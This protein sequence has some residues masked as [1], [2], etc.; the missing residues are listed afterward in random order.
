MDA[1]SLLSGAA[2]VT[3]HPPPAPQTDPESVGLRSHV[4]FRHMEPCDMKAGGET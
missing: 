2:A 1:A 3:A 4:V